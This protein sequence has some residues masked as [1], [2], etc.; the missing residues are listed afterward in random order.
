[1]DLSSKPNWTVYELHDCKNC[2]C[3]RGE[4]GK[5]KLAAA[6]DKRWAYYQTEAGMETKRMYLEKA[7]VKRQILNQLSL[8]NVSTKAR[9]CHETIEK[10]VKML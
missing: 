8:L 6:N 3:S 1:M 2:L 10:L 9:F 7:K 4:K 5:A